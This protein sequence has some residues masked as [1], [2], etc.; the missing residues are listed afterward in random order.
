[1]SHEIRTPLYGLIG[2]L[3][4]L[5]LTSLDNQ[6][7][8]YINK[9]QHS[10]A[11]TLEIISEI[12]DISK[13]ELGQTTLQEVNFCPLEIFEESVNIYLANARGKHLKVLLFSESSIP[14]WVRGDK[15]KIHQII[16]NLINN[17][18]KFTDHG[19]V[20]LR[21]RLVD[22]DDKYATL[23]WQVSDTGSGISQEKS[24]TIFEPFIQLNNNNNNKTEGAGLG[25]SICSKLCDIIGGKLV[26]VSEPGLGSSFSLIMRLPIVETPIDHSFQINLKGIDIFVRAPLREIEENLVEWLKRWG[27]SARIFSKNYTGT[28]KSILINMYPDSLKSL[29]AQW[30]GKQIFATETEDKTIT[31]NFRTAEASVYDI[32]AIA[33]TALSLACNYTH[34]IDYHNLDHSLNFNIRVLVAEDNAINREILREQLLSLGVAPT[35]A[36]DGWQAL[37][38]WNIEPFDMIITDVNM[39]NMDGYELAKNIRQQG[40]SV[41]IIGVT[42]NAMRE[43]GEKCLR[44]GMDA[45]LIKPLRI[46]TL[47]ETLM[48]HTRETQAKK[49]NGIYN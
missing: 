16:N 14:H 37:A 12:L 29:E 1:M 11:T 18:I 45:W 17:A 31:S 7:K 19:R 40:S 23:K 2:N 36:S 22:I 41:P 9:I 5:E 26:L 13:I 24:L 46:N 42:A 15:S 34:E 25:L 8:K 43:E 4:L 47:R 33:R 32:R 21:L 44:A 20:Y 3:E 6:Q 39:P 30:T 35:M 27:A 49:N 10:T 38:E 48:T 28:S